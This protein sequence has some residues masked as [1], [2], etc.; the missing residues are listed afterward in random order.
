MKVWVSFIVGSFVVG[1]L[2]WKVPDEKRAKVAAG[3][4]IAVS[5]AYL[6]LNQI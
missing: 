1:V 2:L 4:A 6:F 3:M 5:V